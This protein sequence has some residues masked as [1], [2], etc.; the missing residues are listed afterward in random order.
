M[1][2]YFWVLY[3]TP[4]FVHGNLPVPFLIRL[5]STIQ[6]YNVNGRESKTFLFMLLIGNTYYSNLPRLKK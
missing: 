4:N 5:P 3:N 2:N 6:S 1:P